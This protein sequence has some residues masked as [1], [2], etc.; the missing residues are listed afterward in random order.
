MA[1]PIKQFWAGALSALA[2]LFGGT[3]NADDPIEWDEDA[4]AVY[5]ARVVAM[6]Y[7]GSPPCPPDHI[8]MNSF[9]D[10]T[11]DPVQPL[12]NSPNIGRQTFRVIQHAQ[13]IDDI[14]IVVS[15][16]RD[17]AGK[18]H[19]IDWTLMEQRACFYDPRKELWD[20][21]EDRDG[22]WDAEYKEETEQTCVT[23][24]VRL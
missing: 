16:Q 11:L 20:N 4:T 21:F 3:A 17:L 5:T 22:D 15:V 9:Y 8:C 23:S 7:V 13:Y 24:T 6:E 14:V 10:L 12:G 18:W 19:L 2:L 1:L